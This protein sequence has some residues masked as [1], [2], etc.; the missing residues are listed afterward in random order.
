MINLR[1][2][3]LT[4]APNEFSE[5]ELELVGV[6]PKDFEMY[7]LKARVE[8]EPCDTYHAIG[9]STTRKQMVVK[10]RLNF[11]GA[12]VTIALHDHHSTRQAKYP[13]G[14]IRH[15]RARRAEVERRF[16]EESGKS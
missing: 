10:Y 13:R 9:A 4:I 1:T 11:D 16:L 2:P 8:F 14:C 5:I 12:T 7:L 15:D 3:D 6:E